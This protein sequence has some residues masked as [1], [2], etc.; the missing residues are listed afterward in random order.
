MKRIITLTF[1]F[2]LLYVNVFS[3]KTVPDGI[4][5]QAIAKSTSISGDV[6]AAER[7]IHVKV[8][9]LKET[10]DGTVAYEES[11]A[12][13]SN[14]DGVF[15]VI[16]GKGTY[17]GGERKLSDINWSL[18]DYFINIK[19]SIEPT[20]D[21]S[22]NPLTAQYDDLGTSQLWTVP[23]AYYANNANTSN[24][25]NQLSDILKSERGGTGVANPVGKT[26][27]LN[28]SLTV[29]GAGDFTITTTGASNITFPNIG[30][31]ATLEGVEVFTNKTLT[32]PILNGT[33]TTTTANL[34]DN[35]NQIANT[36]FVQ[37]VVSNIKSST[38]SLTQAALDLKEDKANKSLD[39][40]LDATS[41]IKY[42]S[43]KAVK[44][45]FDNNINSS[46]TPDATTLLKGKIQLAGDLGGTA[47][48]P[49]VNSVGG[50]SSNTIALL[51]TA[52]QTNTNS[53]TANT[54][55]LNNAT[56]SNL[57]GT[58]VK[59]DLS[60]NFEAGV[61][62]ASLAGNASTTTRLLNPVYIYGNT[63]SGTESITTVLAPN[64]G[65]TGVDNASN[66]IKLGGN[67]TTTSDVILAGTNSTTIRTTNITDVTLPTSGT[68]ATLSGVESLTN[69]T[70]NGVKPEALA[71]G[72]KINGGTLTSTTLTVVGDVT[73]GGVNTGDQLITLTGDVVG[74]G[75]GIINTTINSIGGV[76]SSTISLLPDAVATNTVNI[77]SNTNSITA[78][79]LILNNATN[80]NIPETLVKRDIAGGFEAG[81]SKFTN[82]AVTG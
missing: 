17:V 41:D 39:I 46:T 23:Y 36:E 33:P 20:L 22:Y 3:Q 19:I 1:L 43:A 55:I 4:I 49:T 9:I 6:A 59:R 42:P 45:Y 69:K 16:I 63:F 61:I 12:V 15:T 27:K 35:S 11:Q 58:L 62:T 5:F 54:A 8:K 48:L 80:L 75:T 28:Q 31:M 18:T 77:A 29:E 73:I 50:V 32:S 21:P 64:F 47:A 14:K 68:L 76:S 70:V 40:S 56:S 71:T 51:P 81:N 57:P 82:V 79:S 72:F 74:S 13:T 60:G 65:G 53:I 34:S 67:L 10:I 38:M 25:A 52:I 44:T 7:K 24:S 78:N 66:T 30:T 37:G 26:I 2:T